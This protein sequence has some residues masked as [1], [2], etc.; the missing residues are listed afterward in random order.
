MINIDIKDIDFA[1][2]QDAVT[3]QLKEEV[4]TKKQEIVDEIREKIQSDMRN[5]LLSNMHKG[6]ET[7]DNGFINESNN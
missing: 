7:A 6:D 5:L 4:E 3:E 1:D 2:Q